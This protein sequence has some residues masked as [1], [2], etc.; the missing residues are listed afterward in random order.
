MKQRDSAN[1]AIALEPDDNIIGLAA[2][3]WP[4]QMK[5]MIFSD[6][7]LILCNKAKVIL[8]QQKI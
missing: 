5:L 2:G 7:D 4:I 1:K 6:L 8:C 3:S